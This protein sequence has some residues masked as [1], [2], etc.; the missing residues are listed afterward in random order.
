ML[1][2]VFDIG[3]RE[4][5][6]KNNDFKL[7]DNP[8]VQNGGIIEASKGANPLQPTLGIGLLPGI[9]GGPS[10]RITYEMNRWRTQVIA[11]GA[12]LAKW[13]PGPMVGRNVT[14]KSEISYL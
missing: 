13:T 6:L 10:R 1:D 9:I 3:T 5:V 12:T 8:S 7:T 11:D 2:I 14:V 4:I